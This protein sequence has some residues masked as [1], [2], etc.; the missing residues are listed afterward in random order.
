MKFFTSTTLNFF[1]TLMFYGLSMSYALAIQ[2]NRNEQIKN[3]LVQE[4]L[5]AGWLVM[6]EQYAASDEPLASSLSGFCWV[7]F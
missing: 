2:Y 1:L 7:M 3:T 5:N 6:P 4:K